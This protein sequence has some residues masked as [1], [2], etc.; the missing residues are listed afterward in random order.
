MRA[1]L[2]T[3]TPDAGPTLMWADIDPDGTVRQVVATADARVAWADPAAGEQLAIDATLATL[4]IRAH[5][6]YGGPRSY[7][8]HATHILPGTPRSSDGDDLGLPVA[9]LRVA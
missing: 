8:A 4:E 9:R 1:V 6:R 2:Y 3:V 7:L 5:Q